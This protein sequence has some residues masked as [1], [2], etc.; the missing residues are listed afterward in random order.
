MNRERVLDI[1]TPQ[2]IESWPGGST[3]AL[4]AG[5]G[6]GKSHLIKNALCEI[7]EKTNKKILML[8]HRR[9]CIDQFTEEIERENKKETITIESYQ[10]LECAHLN[11]TDIDLSIYD[12]IVCDEAHYFLNDARFNKTTDI[13]LNAVLEQHTA[14]KLFMSACG[15]DIVKYLNL[16]KKMDTIPYI[17]PSKYGFINSLVFYYQDEYL[18]RFVEDTLRSG[19]KAIMFVESAKAAFDL[20]SRF[21]DSCLFN[22]SEYNDDYYRYVDAN[23][24][25]KM[26]VD[27][28][29]DEQILITTECMDA[30]VNIIDPQVKRI[31]CDIRDTGTLIQC[32]GRRRHKTDDDKIGLYIHAITNKQLGGKIAQL[33]KEL[34]MAEYLRKHSVEDF[35]QKFPREYDRRIMV[36]DAVEDGR[37]TKRINELMFYKARIDLAEAKRIIAYGEYGYCDYMSNLFGVDYRVVEHQD[38]EDERVSCFEA[39]VGKRL[40][41]ESKS[42]L[43][44][45]IGLK[46]KRGRVQ[47]SLDVLNAY[48]TENKLPYVIRSERDNRRRLEDGSDNPQYKK[49]HWMIYRLSDQVCPKNM[50]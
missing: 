16:V 2:T 45:S 1:I 19:D 4:I 8:I 40:Y 46:D 7:A 10:K 27:E 13:A 42:Q 23:R 41:D 50:E 38:Q 32:I 26:L 17:L 39:S 48:L 21:K 43:I 15:D 18:N 31:L 28:R 11:Q 34:R 25:R 35:I 37:A 5:T 20:Y 29:F 14:T 47:K 3:I 22:C 9:N 36:Y 33:Q 12:Y 24:I 6:T 49:T 44:K 30:G